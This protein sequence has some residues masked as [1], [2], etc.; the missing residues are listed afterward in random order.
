MVGRD[1]V[2]GAILE[3]RLIPVIRTDRAG[4]AMDVAKA[5]RKGGARIME[6]T[7]T[8]PGVLK[9]LE[10]MVRVF[11]GEV[12]LGVG[13]VLDPET[14]FMAIA[15]GARFI[16]APSLNME[17]IKIC[18]RYGRVVIPGALTPTE[19]LQAWE[20][21]ADFVKVF[22]ADALGGPGY[23]KALK[24]PL[25]QIP[26][27]PTGGVD[28]HSGPE[29]IRAG[30]AAVA[31]GGGLMERQILLDGNYEAIAQK[32]RAFLQ[33][34]REAREPAGKNLTPF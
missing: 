31:V 3:S 22:P 23:I 4:Q 18:R 9:V 5:L 13:T 12:V 26:L 19:M 17:T 24:G 32:T 15:A 6:I 10:E 7:M 8:I 14:A 28:I 16:V 30:A 29:F 11:A 34:M 20:Q 21:G 2:T 1:R 25:P 27:I 33:A